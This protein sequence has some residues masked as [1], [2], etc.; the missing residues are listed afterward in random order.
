MGQLLTMTASDLRQR[1][2]DRSVI[3]FA[4]VVPL[5]LMYVFNLV[6]GGATD[7]ELEPVTVAVA[8]PADDQLAPVFSEVLTQ[9]EGLDVTVEEVPADQVRG[10][11]DDGDAGV[12]L[13][14]PDGFTAAVMQ[15]QPV[16]VQVIEGDGTGLEADVVISLVDG[17]LAQFTAGSVTAAAAAES[18]LPPADLAEIAQAALESGPAMELAEGEAATEQLSAA[19]ALVAGQAGLF[20]LFT[21]GFG[22][23]GLVTEREQGTLARLHSMP[24][25]PGLIVGAKGLVSFILGVVA[26]SVLLTVGGMFFDVSFGS[27]LPV[28]AL[29]LCVVAATT[30]LMFVIARV[31]RTSEQASIAQSIVALTLGLAG[32]AFFPISGQGLVG[33]LLDLNPIAAFTRGLGITSSGGGLADLGGP[34]AVML[35][36][37][38]IVGLLSRIVPDKGAAL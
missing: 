14:V 37:G 27:P 16:T 34:I 13:V 35:G 23:L 17:V 8:V 19:A 4:L 7:I 29:I 10:V 32:G 25:T 33:V 11:V 38:I 5:A 12:G 15:G 2:R 18:G 21:V 30:S 1:V 6:F 9:V 20:L 3:I 31:A 26:T 22:V 28:A 36:F 24:M